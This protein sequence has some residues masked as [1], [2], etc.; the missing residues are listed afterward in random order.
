M[1]FALSHCGDSDVTLALELALDLPV[2]V[3]LVAQDKHQR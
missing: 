2:E 3:F 1:L